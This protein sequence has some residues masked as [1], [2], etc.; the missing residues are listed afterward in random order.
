[1]LLIL[2]ESQW[3]LNVSLLTKRVQMNLILIESQWNLNNCSKVHYRN[4]P[5]DINRITVEFKLT[6]NCPDAVEYQILIESQWNL[7]CHIRSVPSRG[8]GILIE[9][10]WNLN[11]GKVNENWL[12]TGDINRITVEFKF[13]FI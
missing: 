9:S 8:N 5:N 12:R 2:I 3:N 13:C 6:C 11:N 4:V 10:Q 7:N 1:M